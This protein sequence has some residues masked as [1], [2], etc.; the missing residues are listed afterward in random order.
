MKTPII[1]ASIFFSLAAVTGVF[2]KEMNG[3]IKKIDAATSSV[4]LDSG[5]IL[6]IPLSMD[7][8]TLKVGEKVYVSYSTTSGS[9][10]VKSI[11]PAK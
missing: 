8:A 4:T 10:T 2:A 11:M 6:K 3:T 7:I 9:T 1:A 5:K